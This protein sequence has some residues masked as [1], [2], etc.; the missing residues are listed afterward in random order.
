MKATPMRTHKTILSCLLCTVIGASVAL[1]FAQNGEPAKPKADK[2]RGWF[3]NEA[4]QLV[5]FAVL[6]GLYRDGVPQEAIDIIIP[7]KG[8]IPTEENPAPKGYR[9]LYEH[10]VYMCPLCHPAYEAFVVYSNRKPFVGQKADNIDTFGR[11]F[12]PAIMKLLRSEKKADRLEAIKRL[13]D[14]WVD[15]RL[16]LMRLTKQ[17]RLEWKVRIDALRDEGTKW[18]KQFQAGGH[19]LGA[20]YADWK[21][22]PSCDGSADACK[23]EQPHR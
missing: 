3:D 22:C 12:D 14:R 6:E 13:I 1:T 5:F 15:Q 2:P 16:A 10:F 8:T 19:G 11:E 20:M 4:S 21:F 7:W 9:D 23:L 18:L 17:E